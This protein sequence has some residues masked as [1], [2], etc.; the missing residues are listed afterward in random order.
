MKPIC[1]FFAGL[2]L[3]HFNKPL[4]IGGVTNYKIYLGVGQYPCM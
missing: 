1:T 3:V 2:S 4:V